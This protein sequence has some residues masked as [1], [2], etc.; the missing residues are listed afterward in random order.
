MPVFRSPA[1]RPA[2]L[3]VAIAAFVALGVLWARAQ[4]DGDRGI[5]PVMASNDIDVSGIDVDVTAKNAEEARLEGWHQAARKAWAKLEG[6]NLS[7]SQLQGIVSAI[8][9][10][11]EQIGDR[12]YKARLGVIFDRQRA[13]S[14]LGAAGRAA[15]SAPML[16]IPVTFTGGT[17][18]VYERRNEWQRAWAEYQPGS[19]R[20]DYVRPAGSGADSLLVTYG[21]SGRRSRT[22]WRNILDQFGASDVI[23]AIARLDY[24]YPGGPVKGTFTARYGPDSTYLASFTMDAGN[25]RELP[26]MLDRAVLRMDKIFE[27]ALADGRLTPDPTLASG[28]GQMDP[29]VRQLIDRGEAAQAQRRAAD[30]AAR[31]AQQA[32]ETDDQPTITLPPTQSATVA[33]YV[34]QFA[35]PD[36]GAVDATLSAVNATPG[37]RSA[38]TSSLAIGGTS[39]MRV[40]YAGSLNDLAQALAGRGFS[41]TQGGSAL[42]IRR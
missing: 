29:A 1:M 9:I 8:V 28:G 41:V 20:V 33:T 11:D 40:T 35:T 25:P 2:L 21:Q 4:V 39:V 24:A 37:V 5:P 32:A 42:S 14:Y 16:L 22:W 31:A 13:G 36:A 6:P 34:V 7:D 17:E 38:A 10:E 30:A 18:T 19:S 15:R 23:V 27:S 3:I 26:A 12:R